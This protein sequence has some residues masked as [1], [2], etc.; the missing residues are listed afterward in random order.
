[1]THCLIGLLIVLTF[2]SLVAPLAT[3][4]QGPPPS[5]TLNQENFGPGETLVLTATTIAG[6][7]GP[8]D[9]YL[10]LELPDGRQLFY[11]GDGLFTTAMQPIL[12]NWTVVPFTGEIFSYTLSGCELG[13]RYQWLATFTEPGTLTVLGAPAQASFALDTPSLI[14]ISGNNQQGQPGEVL[15]NPFVVQVIDQF[16]QPLAGCEVTFSV[17]VGDGTFVG[18]AAAPAA[19]QPPWPGGTSSFAAQQQTT[20]ASVTVV[21]GRDGLAAARYQP[22]QEPLQVV[23]AQLRG[24]PTAVVIFRVN[25]GPLA[26]NGT[27][28]VNLAV[29]GGRGYTAN[30]STTNISVF[31]ATGGSRAVLEVIDLQGRFGT[32]FASVLG[33]AV[34]APANRLYAYVSVGVTVVLLAVDTATNTLVEPVDPDG[35]GQ[36]GLTLSTTGVAPSPGQ[37]LHLTYGNLVTVDASRGRIYA[38]APGP[39]EK[40]AAGELVSVAPGSLL[41]IDGHGD[42]LAELARVPVGEVPTGVAVNA[43]THRIYVTNRGYAE[44]DPADDTVTVIDG[45]ALTAGAAIP[46]G[47][48]PVGVKVDERHNVV[49]VANF[50][51]REALG[52]CGAISVIDGRTDRVVQTV[53][54]GGVTDLAVLVGGD[55]SPLPAGLDRLYLN[56]GAVFD[57]HVAELSVSEPC[58]RHPTLSVPGGGKLAINE[59]HTLLFSARRYANAV[60][61]VDLATH[62]PAEPEIVTG[63][64]VGGLAV[65]GHTGRIYVSNFL[66]ASQR[67]FVIEAGGGS[68]TVA[69]VE[70]NIAG[71]SQVEVDEVNGRLYVV[72]H[73]NQGVLL[74]LDRATH[75]ELATVDLGPAFGFTLAVDP[76]ANL[77]YV[78]TS[79]VDQPPLLRV[80]DGVTF[81]LLAEVPFGRA[82]NLEGGHAVAVDEVRN[83]IY[84]IRTSNVARGGDPARNALVVVRGPEF[85]AATRTVRR[86]PHVV[87]EIPNLNLPLYDRQI[88]IDP[89]RQL[90]YVVGSFQGFGSTDVTVLDGYRIV[91]RQGQVVPNPERAVLGGI[92]MRGPLGRDGAPVIPPGNYV[93]PEIAFNRATGLLYV[94]TRFAG[95]FTEGFLSVI[96]GTQVIDSAGNFVTQPH[97]T[98]R[99]AL[100]SQI[101][102]LPAGLDPEFVAVDPDRQRVVV[103]NQSLGALSIFQELSA[104]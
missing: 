95:F 99:G 92:P 89:E 86:E 19:T 61:V 93:S 2:G 43:Q 27:E 47:R 54:T 25:L 36:P 82:D 77:L 7:P 87:A 33:V 29:G 64:S 12:R 62:T 91:D 57:C 76:R 45:E 32:S 46:V 38:V 23:A 50:F 71:P 58:Q 96:D 101:A 42:A 5:L 60:E 17:L 80:F 97:P 100:V 79:G 34:H 88:A 85:D 65:D 15:P 22:G 44:N 41:V 9:V 28:P 70:L 56:D 74:A 20:G 13:G 90:V 63:V 103:T 6:V 8:V 39:V 69:A 73:P 84:V 59:S 55:G 1:M 37:I 40:G 11:Q 51:G 94:V 104:R 66:S 81:A 18:S 48:G 10:V 26:G 49:Y 68:S 14:E 35:D 24:V 83:L 3:N 4:A 21:T 31:D 52:C 98:V 30:S 72:S 16:G 78:S 102:I 53:P 67:L 75:A